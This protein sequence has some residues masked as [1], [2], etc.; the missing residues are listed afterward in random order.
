MTK[1]VSILFV[2]LFLLFGVVGCSSTKEEVAVLEL[3]GKQVSQED[4]D[5][6]KEEYLSH[7]PDYKNLS[8]VKVITH[9]VLKNELMKYVE[10]SEEEVDS[11]YKKILEVETEEGVGKISRGEYA[12]NMI[13][14]KYA[15]K[16]LAT[17]E[18]KLQEIYE[19]LSDSEKSSIPFET[20]KERFDYVYEAATYYKVID[21]LPLQKELLEKAD[22]QGIKSLEVTDDITIL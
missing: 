13:K 17:S 11:E 22:I 5:T 1:F 9:Y 8:Q 4:L 21:T 18:E 16:D 20:F 19:K 12:L 7:L 10:L 6:Y 14:E 3:K 15:Q 2:S